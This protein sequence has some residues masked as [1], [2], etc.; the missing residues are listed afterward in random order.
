MSLRTAL[1]LALST[2]ALSTAFADGATSVWVGG[3]R[4]WVDLPMQSTKT[5]EAVRKEFEAFRQNPVVANGSSIWVGGEKGWV[6]LPVQSTISR[7]VVRKEFEAFRRNP[8]M[9]DGAR[10]VGGEIGY[11]YPP[12]PFAPTQR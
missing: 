12:R 9:G 8:V 10:Y 2:M 11:I 4:G 1:V 5:R 3:E 7:D 6:D